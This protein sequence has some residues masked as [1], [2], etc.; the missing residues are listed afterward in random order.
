MTLQELDLA[1]IVADS[2]GF[3]V[4]AYF[5]NIMILVAYGVVMRCLALVAMLATT[6]A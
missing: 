1:S 4:R 3:D 5:G 2:L 6:R